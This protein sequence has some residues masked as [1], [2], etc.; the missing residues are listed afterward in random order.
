MQEGVWYAIDAIHGETDLSSHT[1]AA[2]LEIPCDELVAVLQSLHLHKGSQ[3]AA[4]KGAVIA[5]YLNDALAAQTPPPS[6]RVPGVVK[7]TTDWPRDAA[8]HMPH[9]WMFI[10]PFAEPTHR[11]RDQTDPGSRTPQPR[12][13]PPRSGLRS[14]GFAPIL[15]R[16]SDGAPGSSSGS[17]GGSSTPPTEPSSTTPNAPTDMAPPPHMTLRQILAALG[18]PTPYVDA[19]GARIGAATLD[20]SFHT[21][22]GGMSATSGGRYQLVA[23]A[24]SAVHAVLAVLAPD[25]LLTAAALATPSRSAS[26]SAAEPLRRA[27]AAPAAEPTGRARLAFLARSE[28]ALSLVHSYVAATKRGEKMAIRAPILAAFTGDYTLNSF[29]QTFKL[30]LGGEEVTRYGWRAGKWHGAIWLAGQAAPPSVTQRW[31][32]PGAGE[33][34]TLPPAK[35]VNAV[36]FLTSDECLQREA[37]GTRR[38]KWTDRSTLELPAGERVQCKAALWKL[39]VLKHAES[40]RVSQSQLNELANMTVP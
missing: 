29:N 9:F 30:Q 20:R 31:R 10:P 15:G 28:L 18:R 32:L 34:G 6:Y 2:Q 38:L 22:L 19:S 27:L 1:L 35:I 4:A 14:S 7:S 3:G 37:W 39:Y 12:Q 5:S 24:A 36:K 16:A 26:R 21:G 23:A 33:H 17:S 40:L 8:G 11:P 25:P 13:P